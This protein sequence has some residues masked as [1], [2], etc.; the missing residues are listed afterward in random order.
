MEY[1]NKIRAVSVK[2]DE[3]K[4]QLEINDIEII[5]YKDYYKYLECDLFDVVMTNYENTDIS[6]FV[7]DEGL[8]KENIIYRII[9]GNNVF[10]LAGNMVFT[11]GVDEEGETLSLPEHISTEIIRDWILPIGKIN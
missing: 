3:S 1:K 5:N 2:F 11:G 6:I 8:F 4:N 7:D 10:K 9:I